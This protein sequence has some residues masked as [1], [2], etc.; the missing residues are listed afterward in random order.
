MYFSCLF[1]FS[2]KWPKLSF[3]LALEFSIWFYSRLQPWLH[4]RRSWRE[5]ASQR[6]EGRTLCPTSHHLLAGN[7]F[8]APLCHGLPRIP[9]LCHSACTVFSPKRSSDLQVPFHRIPPSS[10]SSRVASFVASETV[11]TPSVRGRLC[12]SEPERPCR[13]PVQLMVQESYQHWKDLPVPCLG[14]ALSWWGQREWAWALE[15]F[16][17]Q[18]EGPCLRGAGD[19][20]ATGALYSVWWDCVFFSMTVPRLWPCIFSLCK[21]Y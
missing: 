3:W 10:N 11:L 4:Q 14:S 19:Q 7:W 6:R 12:Q 13:R 8:C 2:S 5:W 9:E 15:S 21:H 16:L 18:S 20:K 17:P 1:I